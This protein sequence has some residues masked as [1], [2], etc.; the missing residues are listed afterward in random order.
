MD[1]GALLDDGN[2]FTECVEHDMRIILL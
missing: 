2:I 1:E